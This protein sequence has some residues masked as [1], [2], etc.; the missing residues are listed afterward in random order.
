LRSLYSYVLL[1]P[2]RKKWSSI[3]CNQKINSNT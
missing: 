1:S 2:A 3:T